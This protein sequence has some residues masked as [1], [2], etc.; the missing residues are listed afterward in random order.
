[1][2]CLHCVEMSN[3]SVWPIDRTLSSAT[4]PG[5]SVPES[6]G[7]EGILCIPQSSTDRSL[8]TWWLNIISWTLIE[9]V[10]PFCSDVFGVFYS[11]SRLGC[12][13]KW[14]VSKTICSFN[15]TWNDNLRNVMIARLL[16]QRRPF[17]NSNK[18]GVRPVDIMT[19][20]S[21]FYV[22]PHCVTV[23]LVGNRLDKPSPNTG[24]G[25]LHFTSCEC[26]WERYESISSLSHCLCLIWII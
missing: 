13:L 1:M 9:G 22:C 18:E 6:N 4:T 24:L 16:G 14:N 17:S 10:L 7:N 11:P 20:D 2:I 3:S 26:H 25:C 21:G 23:I 5:Q 12:W 19:F 15:Y 8:A